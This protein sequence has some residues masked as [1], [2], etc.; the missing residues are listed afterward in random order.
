MN[1]YNPTTPT[2][3]NPTGRNTNARV[4]TW[5]E[6]EVFFSYETP[7][8]YRGPDPN[9]FGPDGPYT[10]AIRIANTFSRT[11]ARHFREL[12]CANF[13]VVSQETFDAVLTSVIG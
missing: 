11:T 4:L 8:A 12:G 10:T 3:T 5:G 2:L 1:R 6:C 9:A 7:I 13:Q